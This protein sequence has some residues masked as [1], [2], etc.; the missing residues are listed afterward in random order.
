MVLQLLLVR[1]THIVYAHLQAR[2]SRTT[3]VQ[4][5][6]SPTS[7]PSTRI[8]SK[9]VPFRHQPNYITLTRMLV[10]FSHNILLLPPSESL[11]LHQEQIQS[12]LHSPFPYHRTKWLHNIEHARTLLLQLEHGAQNIKVQRVKRDIVHDLAEKRSTI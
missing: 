9:E 8:T 5:L 4:P 3:I 2:M 12:D 11:T 7:S 1:N 10:R 6:A